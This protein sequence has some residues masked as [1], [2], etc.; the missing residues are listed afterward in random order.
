MELTEAD[1]TEMRAEMDS[2]ALALCSGCYQERPPKDFSPSAWENRGFPADTRCRDCIHRRQY[3][4]PLSIE[5]MRVAA[6]AFNQSHPDLVLTYSKRYAERH[7]ARVAARAK[8]TWHRRRALT[9]GVDAT[10]TAA[11][12]RRVLAEGRER[13]CVYC[14]AVGNTLDHLIPLGRGSHT[15]GNIVPACRSCNSSKNARTPME[16]NRPMRYVPS[17]IA[18]LYDTQ[19]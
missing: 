6:R 13:G 8:A 2:V 5:A 7:P 1:Y 18:P 10:L 11:E 9:R 19:I 12:I 3:A 16:W 17:W 15:L 14:P 4:T